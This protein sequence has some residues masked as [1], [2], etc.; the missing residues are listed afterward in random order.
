MT[1]AGD[2][3]ML[4]WP[5]WLQ[6]RGAHLALQVHL[7]P[8]ARRNAIV[9]TH[10]GRL[11]ISVTAPARDGAANLALLE[12]LSQRLGLKRSALTLASGA[13]TRSKRVEVDGVTDPAAVLAALTPDP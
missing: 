13:H 12:L 6:L 7:Q 9:G 2:S 3:R 5:P 1:K 8:Q 10:A 11:K 4:D